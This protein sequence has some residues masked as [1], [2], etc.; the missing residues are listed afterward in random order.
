[1]GFNPKKDKLG[2]SIEFEF[3][4]GFLT[5]SSI[6]SRRFIELIEYLKSFPYMY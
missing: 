6:T 5:N 4:H 1:M 3:I 2:V